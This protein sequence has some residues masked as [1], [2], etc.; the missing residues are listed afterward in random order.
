MSVALEPGCQVVDFH[1][2]DEHSPNPNFLGPQGPVPGVLHRELEIGVDDSRP[3]NAGVEDEWR[4]LDH[5]LPG[6]ARQVGRSRHPEF[7][8]CQNF[9]GRLADANG[10]GGEIAKETMGMGAG[11]GMRAGVGMGTGMGM[12]AGMG[13]GIVSEQDSQKPQN[14]PG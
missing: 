7:E 8:C 4:Y 11:T 1:C 9:R 10:E 3:K 14:C 6:S 2:R 13:M 5:Q 12:R